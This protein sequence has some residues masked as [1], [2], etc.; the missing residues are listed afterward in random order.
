MTEQNIV[1][2][3]DLGTT[4][5]V[6]SYFTNN[7]SH[8]LK[9]GA[10]KLIP[11]KI[12]INSNNNIYCGNYIPVGS[13]NIINSFKI[14]IGKD[15]S[16][17]RNNIKYNIMDILC[18][19]INHLKNQIIKKFPNLKVYETV[20]TVPSNFTDN[21][22]EII[23]QAFINNMFDVIRIINEPSAAALAYGLQH[24]G[25]RKIM[26]IDTGG[27]T[28]D[29]TILQKD[30]NFFQVIHSIGL[31]DL[32]GNN[33]TNVIVKDII[34]KNPEL[35]N[36]ACDTLFYLAQRLK[37]KLTYMEQFQITL[38]NGSNY[39]LSAKQFE[40]L[41]NEL[42]NR[43]DV[44]ISDLIKENDDIEYFILVGGSSKMK[45]LQE[46]IYTITGKKPWIHPN[47]DFV[48]AEGASLYGGIIKNLFVSTEDVLLV[49][50]LPL[51][52]GV[53][54]VDG[55][56]SI[57]IP[58]DTPLPAKRSQKYTTDSP[59]NNMIQ[60]SIYQGERSI[61]NKNILIGTIE[62]DKV[63]ATGMPVIEICFRIDLNGIINI[64]II[65]IKTG[66]EKSI[67]IKD[68]PKYDVNVLQ[69]IL[70]EAT[71]NNDMDSM[72]SLQ[73]QRLYIIKTKIE[74]ALISLNINEKISENTKKEIQD[75]LNKIEEDLDNK[76]NIELLEII[77]SIDNE[78]GNLTTNNSV[79]EHDD[80]IDKKMDDME[81]ILLDC[82]RSDVIRKAN[83]LLVQ[84]PEW[85]EYITPLLDSLE[86]TNLTQ[87]YLQDKYDILK[88]LQDDNETIERDYYEELKNIYIYLKTEFTEGTLEINENMKPDFMLLLQ[89]YEEIIN[90]ISNENN[91]SEKWKEELERFNNNCE[92]IYKKNN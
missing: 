78:F 57:I 67:L 29:I 62:F 21:T 42:L 38:T 1:F 39:Y 61:A 65:D 23:R 86:I 20:V 2:G 82:L 6:I 36:N 4:N 73:L 77:Q 80:N 88:E 53:E 7:K 40:K 51:S 5:T 52:L 44:L 87:E 19:F 56:F 10:F 11:S 84:N 66:I 75:K 85:S 37:E 28:M 58:K 46:K 68:I 35:N 91:S 12:Y 90:N 59:G 25:E 92:E 50:V 54:T 55:N 83:L 48:V 71:L 32:G 13:T 33:F 45:I 22:R 18:I 63:S 41:S 60:V 34:K 17:E 26:V 74:N 81:K 14:E 30:D 79:M 43:V 8:I 31:N 64:I 69:E 72:E 24:S 70:K 89:N 76:S 15:Y 16:V 9:D 3:I 47:L 49:D 27:G